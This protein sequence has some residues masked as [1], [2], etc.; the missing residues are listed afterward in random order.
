MTGEE[1]ADT[2]TKL[3]GQMRAESGEEGLR[4]DGERML[5]R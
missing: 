5:R 4:S 3:T 1:L 2:V